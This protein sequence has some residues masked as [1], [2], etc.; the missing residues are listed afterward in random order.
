MVTS[1]PEPNP[2]A[3][4][5]EVTPPLPGESAA[6]RLTAQELAAFVGRKANYY[7][8]KWNI[9]EQSIPRSTGFNWA[10]F[11]LT[12]LWLPYRKMYRAT[13]ILWGIIVLES[14]LEEFVWVGMLGRPEP[15]SGWDAATGL[16]I[17]IFCGNF[18]NGWYLSH[19]RRAIAEVRASGLAGDE[20]LQALARRGGTNMLA[21]LGVLVLVVVAFA[22]LG[23]VTAMI[24][25]E[26]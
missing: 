13:A 21:A 11:F 5:K 14:I 22:A 24:L 15:S 19:A 4:P 8:A 23:A 18:A 7:L 12:G 6:A 17:A 1:E 20:Y 26:G 9:A 10:A 16:V 2:Y 3:P 25:P